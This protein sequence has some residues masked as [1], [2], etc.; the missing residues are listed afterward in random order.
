MAKNTNKCKSCD[1]MHG[2]LVSDCCN[3]EPYSNGDWSTSDFGICWECKDHCTYIRL[4]C[5]ECKN[6]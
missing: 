1:D 6:L 4:E 2:S 3:A 5:E